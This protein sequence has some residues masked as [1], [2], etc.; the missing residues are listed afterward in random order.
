LDSRLDPLKRL[1]LLRGRDLSLSG[2]VLNSPTG[3]RV[4]GDLPGRPG[5]HP[6]CEVL[7][8]LV[9]L[10]HRSPGPTMSLNLTARAVIHPVCDRLNRLIDLVRLIRQL[11]DTTEKLRDL[12]LCGVELPRVNTEADVCDV[13]HFLPQLLGTEGRVFL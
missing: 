10:V 3:P 9:C 6:I 5:F 7:D 12:T 13:C 4:S 1:L 2:H 11:A 8:R